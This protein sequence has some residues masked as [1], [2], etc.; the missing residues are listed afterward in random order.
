[1]KAVAV[2]LVLIAGAAVVL[3]YGN[4]SNSWVVGGLIGGLAA[5]LLSIPISLSLFS[6]LS[7][8]HDERIRAED[9]LVEEEMSFSQIDDDP[10]FSLR[11][12]RRSPRYIESSVHNPQDQYLLDD[13]RFERDMRPRIPPQ[14]RLPSGRD[15]GPLPRELPAAPI[16]NQGARTRELNASAREAERTLP[17]RKHYP[18]LPA[19]ETGVSRVKQ[20]SEA[21]RTARLEAAQLQEDNEPWT[22]QNLRRNQPERSAREGDAATREPGKPRR[23]RQLPGQTNQP[24]G[25]AHGDG[26]ADEDAF[27]REERPLRSRR[28]KDLETDALSHYPAEAE[29]E[30]PVIELPHAGTRHPNIEQEN[31]RSEDEIDRSHRTRPLIRRAPYLYEDDPLRQ[32][33]SQHIDVPSVRRSSRNESNESAEYDDD[34]A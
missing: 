20:R 21:L 13:E 2:A 6:Y 22:T 30:V 26:R 19:S 29:P 11:H 17:R 24:A 12:N 27:E 23:T 31:Q 4:T 25:R 15:S 14:R 18:G 9:A 33:L 1:M 3:W 5:L 7:R 34:D 8:R 32:E 28:R 10:R 16:P